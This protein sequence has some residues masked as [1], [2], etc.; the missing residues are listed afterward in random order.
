M[1]AFH[2]LSYVVDHTR[3]VSSLFF[4]IHSGHYERCVTVLCSLSLIDFDTADKPLPHPRLSDNYYPVTLPV[5]V[6]TP[7]TSN[8]KREVACSSETLVPQPSC[9]RRHNT[10]HRTNV[11]SNVPVISRTKGNTCPTWHDAIGFVT[12]LTLHRIT[13]VHGWVQS[14][15]RHLKFNL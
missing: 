2:S 12:K 6:L 3:E 14:P 10:K 4:P 9:I 11:S 15:K 1:R 8:L 13:D 7:I 5:W